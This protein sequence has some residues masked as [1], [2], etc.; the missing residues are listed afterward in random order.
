MKLSTW[1]VN[2]LRASLNKGLSDYLQT[3]NADIIALQETK[4]N[5]PVENF[6]LNNYSTAWN[7]GERLGYSGTACLFK[8]D[9]VSVIY[10]LGDER[11]DKEGRLIT[12]KYPSFFFVNVYTPNSQGGL[13]RWYYRLAWDEAF[14]KYIN[15]LSSELPVVICG[16][17]NVAHKYIDVYPENLSNDENPSGFK[18]EERDGLDR[19]IESGFTD[20]YRF[21]H[22][23]KER[24][25]TWWSNRLN[26]RSENRGWRIDYFFVTDELCDKIQ[27]VD[28][29][30]NII[31]SDHCP[32]EM[33]INL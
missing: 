22:P 26:K 12:L 10:G 8:K 11:F 7:C 15:K 21:L 31:G 4:V 16:D 28:I 17:F 32:V 14:T 19:L 20:A 3:S 1:N 6:I 5:E 9:P 33:V 13:K 24:A 27:S 30:A 18:E 29:Q 25:Y 2:G 23:D